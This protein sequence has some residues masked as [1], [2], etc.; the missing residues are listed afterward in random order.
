[1]QCNHVA[2]KPFVKLCKVS[3]PNLF[4]NPELVVSESCSWWT[5]FYRCD[6]DTAFVTIKTASSLMYGSALYTMTWLDVQ[7]FTLCMGR[8][9]TSHSKSEVVHKTYW[10]GSLTK[11]VMYCSSFGNIRHHCD[12]NMRAAQFQVHVPS[13]TRNDHPVHVQSCSLPRC[14]SQSKCCFLS[15]QILW[16]SYQLVSPTFWVAITH[17]CCHY[18][19]WSIMPSG[20]LGIIQISH[21]IQR[22]RDR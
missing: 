9:F 6:D 19:L 17:S 7:C 21:E 10:L 1:M 8:T 4:K 3:L 22:K 5:A 18:I 20:Y 11:K 13:S 14:T 12:S 16:A 2:M 15:K